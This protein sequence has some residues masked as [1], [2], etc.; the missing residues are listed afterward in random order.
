M[1]LDMYLKKCVY[2]SNFELS[3]KEENDKYNQILSILG[4]S[5]R[6]DGL[7]EIKIPV[8]YWRKANQIH[9]WFVDNVQNGTDDCGDYHCSREQLEELNTVIKKILTAENREEEAQ[10]LLPTASG[11]FFGSTDFDE[12]Y[13]EDLIQTNEMLDQILQSDGDDFVYHSSW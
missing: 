2:V 9:K 12:Y 4:E 11:F 5:S 8:A 6:N 1:G 10:K 3:G 7:M 13:F